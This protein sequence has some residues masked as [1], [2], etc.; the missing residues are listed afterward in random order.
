MV[1]DETPKAPTHRV[2][3]ISIKLPATLEELL[4]PKRRR[5]TTM[6][7]RDDRVVPFE[8]EK[9]KGA[10]GKSSIASGRNYTPETLRDFSEET[11]EILETQTRFRHSG[12]ATPVKKDIEE[13]VLEV[14]DRRQAREISREIA[15]KLE[16]PYSRVLPVVLKMIS[17]RKLDST[18]DFYRRYMEQREEVRKRMIEIPFDIEFDSTDKQLLVHQVANGKPHTL[19][20]ERL[21][22]LI[23][24][25]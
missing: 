5:I 25:R 4:G 14:F 19:D 18:G 1:A 9:I 13:A 24:E 21:K 20:E 2:D 23:T 11:V 8:P 3:G 16:V 6:R 15:K 7:K 17:E 12:T 10:V 22:A